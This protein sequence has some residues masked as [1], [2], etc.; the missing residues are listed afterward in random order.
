[1]KMIL[2]TGALFFS[3][4]DKYNE[5]EVIEAMAYVE[6][7][8]NPCAE[9]PSGDVGYL[10][11]RPIYVDEVNRVTPYW[12]SYNDRYSKR[13]SILMVLLMWEYKYKNESL[14][15]KIRRHNGGNN[16]CQM[17]AT[18]VY[19]NKVINYLNKYC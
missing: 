18:E 14:E 8:H 6:S 10:Q 4:P 9:S 12:F 7:R 1:M 19:L 5:L 15:C 17:E 2:L 13:K 16:G 3:T 11:I